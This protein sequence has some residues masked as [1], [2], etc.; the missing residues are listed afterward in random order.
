MHIHFPK[1]D[2]TSR[3]AGAE[4]TQND[5][6]FLKG[7]ALVL[8]LLHHLF[9]EQTGL[10]DDWLIH[11]TGV[12]QTMGNY[13]KLCVAI[14]VFLSGY[15]VA[16]SLPGGAN[17]RT[18]YGK[19]F[20]KLYLNYWFI[21]LLFV[22]VGIF[23]F[24][25]TLSE[26]Y[27]GESVGLSLLLDWLGLSNSFLRSGYNITWWFYSCI[28]LLYLLAPLLDKAA[29][30]FPLVGLVG[31]WLFM[32]FCRVEWIV[33]PIRFYLFPF[34]LGIVCAHKHWISF[35]A[36]WSRKHRVLALLILLITLFLRTNWGLRA[37]GLLALEGAILIQSC[38]RQ[39]GGK[40][41]RALQYVGRHSFNIFLFHTFLY[42]Y[43][44]ESWIFWSRNPLLIFLTLL[45]SSLLI[46]I[47]IE[48]IKERIGFY[49]LQ[50]RIIRSLDR[51]PLCQAYE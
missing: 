23:V 32:E 14:F 38:Q 13:A 49:T 11:G 12:V 28:L 39:G 40:W 24:G 33:G 22:P 47:G 16:K 45:V 31:A 36:D 34:L 2:C 5:T 37:D 50:D 42:Y 25:R 15:G 9:Y 17:L 46:S 27:A 29:R 44:F 3:Y 43:Y 10:Y 4:L 7:I 35:G 20:T 1:V 6:L 26:A 19:R 8:L 41:S 21:W 30:R 51:N 18:F 48:W